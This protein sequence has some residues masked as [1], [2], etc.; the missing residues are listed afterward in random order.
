MKTAVVLVLAC[1]ILLSAAPARAAEVVASH[2]TRFWVNGTWV[3]AEN[4][5]VGDVFVTT[6]GKR[7]IVKDVESVSLENA[8]C[9]GLVTDSTHEGQA[10]TRVSSVAHV[11]WIARWWQ[12][13]HAF[14]R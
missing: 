7:A 12:R 4:L 14:F 11:N 5:K 2:D 1:M 3:P 8:S 9:Y 6:D 10:T 13:V